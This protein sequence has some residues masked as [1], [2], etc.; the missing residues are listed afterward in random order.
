MLNTGQ[1]VVAVFL[2]SEFLKRDKKLDTSEVFYVRPLSNAEYVVGKIWGNL[3][4][5]LF[6][7]LLVLAIEC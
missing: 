3:R 1:A 5:F 7:N 4:V 6:L 2:S